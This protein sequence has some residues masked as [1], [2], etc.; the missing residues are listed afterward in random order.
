[1]RKS[2]H[3]FQHPPGLRLRCYTCQF[4]ETNLPG[5]MWKD[6]LGMFIYICF[7]RC[8]LSILEKK[9]QEKS[10]NLMCTSCSIAYREWQHQSMSINYPSNR[11][12][13]SLLTPQFRF[14]PHCL[15]TVHEFQAT[16]A[17]L[18]S[19]IHDISQLRNLRWTSSNYELPYLIVGNSTLRAVFV[20]QFPSPNTK[21]C[22]QKFSNLSFLSSSQISLSW[23]YELT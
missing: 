4:A 18:Y 21:N 13:H 8:I 3:D 9:V 10:R 6:F 11:G 22:L 20:E 14:H 19:P 5:V 15:R 2:L 23:I 12:K 17:I 16:N 7:S 1:M